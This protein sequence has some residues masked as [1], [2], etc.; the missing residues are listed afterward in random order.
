VPILTEQQK[1][2]VYADEADVLNV[3]LFGVTA[4]QWREQNPDLSGNMRDDA[5]I[6]HLV[7]LIN[8]ENLNA[9]M[10]KTGLP[11]SERLLKLNQIAKKQLAL[12]AESENIKKIGAGKK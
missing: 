10:I 6:L 11:Q 4:K 1:K 3:A 7:V 9:E 8:L 12:F 5:D 2:F